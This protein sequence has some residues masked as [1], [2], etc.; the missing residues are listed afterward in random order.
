[1]LSNLCQGTHLK[2]KKL[3]RADIN[4]IYHFIENTSRMSFIEKK[5]ISCENVVGIIRSLEIKFHDE[6]CYNYNN[7]TFICLLQT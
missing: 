2:K 5:D 6:D 7:I 4:K 1:M 3:L